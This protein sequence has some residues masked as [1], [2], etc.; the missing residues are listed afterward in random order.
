MQVARGGALQEKGVISRAGERILFSGS[1]FSQ[2]VIITLN[3]RKISAC[4]LKHKP[5]LQYLRFFCAFAFCAAVKRVLVMIYS[6]LLLSFTFSDIFRSSY[7]D[8]PVCL[9]LLIQKP[10]G[11]FVCPHTAELG[12]IAYDNA[13]M[14]AAV[15][16]V[17]MTVRMRA[18]MPV[19]TISPKPI[20]RAGDK[21]RA[22][23]LSQEYLPPNSARANVIIAVI[24]K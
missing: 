16:I 9:L 13:R 4:F 1:Y 6:F 8:S 17:I 7:F 21:S 18:S 20:V 24:M 19:G 23:K 15:N 2:S 5:Q 3:N 11:A 14:Q 22:I 10:C 12:K